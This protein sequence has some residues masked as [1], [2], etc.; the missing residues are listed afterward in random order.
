M[1]QVKLRGA[2]RSVWMRVVET[3]N[4][5]LLLPCILFG[6]PDSVRRNQEPIVLS[7]IFS[8]VLR[9]VGLGH[10]LLAGNEMAQQQATAFVRVGGLSVVSDLLQMLCRQP[11]GQG[12]PLPRIAHSNTSFL[13]HKALSREPLP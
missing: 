8:C 5:Q 2:G 11:N 9:G 7:T 4:L 3:Q 12:W 6:V 10:L 1:I 13:R